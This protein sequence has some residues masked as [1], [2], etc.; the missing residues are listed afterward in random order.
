MPNSAIAFLLGNTDKDYLYKVACYPERFPG[1]W[2]T[3]GLLLASPEVVVCF[4]DF[5]GKVQSP[6]VRG[7][8]SASGGSRVMFRPAKP[9]VCT[10]PAIAGIH[11]AAFWLLCFMLELP[12]FRKG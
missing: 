12:D 9:A 8:L 7:P 2:E 1:K 5:Q 10:V 11:L 4:S 3:T 6:A